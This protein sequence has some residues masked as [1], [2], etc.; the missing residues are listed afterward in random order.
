ML[1][2]SISYLRVLKVS[3]IKLSSSIY[4]TNIYK[5]KYSL[6][7]LS[8]S[9]TQTRTQTRKLFPLTRIVK[10][11]SFIFPLFNTI[12][13]SISSLDTPKEIEQAERWLKKFTK[14]KIPKD[15]IT[16]TFARSSGP[17]GQN[18]NK[19]NTKVDMRFNLNEATWIPEYARKKLAIQEASRLNKKGEFMITSD[20]SRSQVKNIED[21]VDKLYEIILKAAEI[22]KAPS[23]ETL[24]RIEQLYV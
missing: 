4:S 21:C 23:E 10:D 12:K 1:P 7:T 22:P 9:I 3:Y 19:V 15:L 20:K 5:R 6:S 18:V 17:G 11:F 24:K 8:K 16:F 2:K 14:E 13:R